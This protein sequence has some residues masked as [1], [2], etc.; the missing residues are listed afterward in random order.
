MRYG[1]SKEDA[2]KEYC[3]LC[4]Q[5]AALY[6]TIAPVI[7]Q[8]DK[9]VYNCRFDKAIRAATAGQHVYVS[10]QFDTYIEIAFY[11]CGKTFQLATIKTADL[12]DRKRIDADL[13]IADA[14]NRRAQHLKDAAQAEKVAGDIDTIKAQLESLKRAYNGIVDSVP[15]T[16]QDIYNIKRIY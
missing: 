10:K 13:L 7:R 3:D 9:K 5:A 2:V 6:A 15:Y 8:F 16:I 4:R 14:Q 1:Q 12:I 11:E